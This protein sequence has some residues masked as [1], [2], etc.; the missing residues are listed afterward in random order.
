MRDEDRTKEQLMAELIKLRRRNAE[1][2]DRTGQLMGEL[3]ELRRLIA[4][5]EEREQPLR[6]GEILVKMGYVT[7]Q[8]L[9]EALIKQ[10]ELSR[11]GHRQKLLS[12]MVE[13]GTITEEQLR[14]VLAIQS[15]RISIR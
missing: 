9:E 10:E 3:G 14:T 6:T 15:A 11:L 8:Q 5:L 7:R 13:S 2:E 4:E 12:I 1:L